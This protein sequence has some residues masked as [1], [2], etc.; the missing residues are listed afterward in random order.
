MF[1]MPL[2]RY[3]GI[4]AEVSLDVRNEQGADCGLDRVGKPDD[5]EVW[6]FKGTR[7][8]RITEYHSL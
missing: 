7:P 5:L 6:A 8:Q 1:G 2:A 4:Q 3:G